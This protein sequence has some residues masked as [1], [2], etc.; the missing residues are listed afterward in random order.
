MLVTPLV[1]QRSMQKLFLPKPLA[2]PNQGW[3]MIEMAI[4]IYLLV[5]VQIFQTS[6]Y[7]TTATEISATSTVHN[8]GCTTLLDG[9]GYGLTK[10]TTLGAI[11]SF[12]PAEVQKVSEY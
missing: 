9:R 12:A 5:T 1:W 3:T 11:F 6:Y 7:K 4:W 10:T 8:L 2:V